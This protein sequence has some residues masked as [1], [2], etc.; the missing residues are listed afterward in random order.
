MVD[1]FYVP[2]A[3]VAALG[4]G[5]I[6]GTFFAF[7]T[8]VMRALA[9]LPPGSGLSA[10]QSINVVVLNPAFLG[11]FLGT[12]LLS[13]AAVACAALRWDRPG[14]AWVSAGGLL[15]LVGTFGVTAAANVPMNDALAAVSATDPDAAAKWDD[16]VARWTAWNHVRTAAAL[17]ALGSFVVGLRQ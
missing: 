10:M 5:L 13:A 7:S 16:Y 2:I 9:K 15:Y 12:T 6:A 1:H 14:S 11:V 3:F 17:A 4:S 8:F